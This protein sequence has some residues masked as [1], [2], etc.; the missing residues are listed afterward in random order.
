MVHRIWFFI[1]IICLICGSGLIA[2][3]SYEYFQV[4]KLQEE[5]SSTPTTP[6]SSVP[7]PS[8]DFELQIIGLG[9]GLLVSGVFCLVIRKLKR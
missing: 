4:I 6:G 2:F 9:L 1:G 5:Y 8:F 7:Y 3:G